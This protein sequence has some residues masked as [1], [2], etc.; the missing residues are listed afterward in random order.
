MAALDNAKRVGSNVLGAALLVPLLPVALLALAFVL[1]YRAARGRWLQFRF[2]R[3]HGRAGKTLVFVY[4]DSPIWRQRIVDHVLP[5]LAEHAVLLNWSERSSEAWRRRPIE[6][7]VFEFWR[8]RRAFNP[9]A[10]LVPRSGRVE[11]IRFWDAYREY[12][13]GRSTAVERLEAELFA[14]LESMTGGPGR[15]DEAANG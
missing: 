3:S 1:P 2:R 5:E 10:I 14:R 11:T 8:G 9:M 6:V 12:R 15:S 13:N 4:S 7:R